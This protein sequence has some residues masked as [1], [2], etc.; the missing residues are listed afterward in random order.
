V[1]WP[2]AIDTTNESV[3]NILTLTGSIVGQLVFG[4]LADRYGRQKLYGV[5]LIIVTVATLGLAQSSY[6]IPVIVNGTLKTSMKFLSWVEFWRFIMG[7]GIGAEYPLSAVITSGMYRNAIFAMY[8]EYLLE[9]A[10]TR[11]R[12]RMLASVFIMQPLGQL[13]A[14]IIGL[15]VLVALDRQ[16]HLSQLTDDQLP[17]V[18]DKHWRWVTGLGAI[19]AIIALI[20]RLTIPESGRWTLDV[21]GDADRAVLE[22]RSHF[23]STSNPSLDEDLELDGLD[24][25]LEP[26]TSEQADLPPPTY[27]EFLRNY[28]LVDG[29]WRYLAATSTCWFLLDFAYYGIQINI[30]R[31]LAKL[32]AD[33]SVSVSNHY[34]SWLPDPS[35]PNVNHTISRVIVENSTRAMI[36]TS[37]GSLVGSV[38]LIIIIP[39]ISR[40]KFLIWS[41]C[42]LGVIMLVFGGSFL[43]TFQHKSYSWSLFVFVLSQLLFNLGPNTLTFIASQLSPFAHL[44]IF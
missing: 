43:G 32:F 38:L 4:F 14:Y 2:N 3:I 18:I 17:Y 19:P 12:P 13:F 35:F 37:I 20:F 6:G 28:F 42:G 11:S 8:A 34:P 31:L 30:P 22:T 25:A 1:Y 9:W 36:A 33:K 15:V 29:N 23:G 5:E 24:G 27:R 10:S 16:Y 26:E 21:Q 40:R 39:Y 41:F 44:S 7:I